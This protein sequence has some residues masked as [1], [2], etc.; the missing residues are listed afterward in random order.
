[1]AKAR[2]ASKRLWHGKSSWSPCREREP[3]ALPLPV[4]HPR[5]GRCGAS[6]ESK[7]SPA[8]KVNNF[9]PA[10]IRFRFVLLLTN[11]LWT[12]AGL[13]VDGLRVRLRRFRKSHHLIP[14]GPSGF[15]IA[16]GKKRTIQLG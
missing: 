7:T 8:P 1:M 5:A 14:A 6:S 10:R 4:L 12:A 11:A 2:G 15:G 9:L 3:A 16:A 13:F